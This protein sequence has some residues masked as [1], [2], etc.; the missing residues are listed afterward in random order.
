M[1]PNKII[2]WWPTGL[3]VILCGSAVGWFIA[4]VEYQKP[5]SHAKAVVVDNY[6]GLTQSVTGAAKTLDYHV[7]RVFPADKKG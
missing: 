7:W 6:A 4:G 5:S 3:I 2:H 1:R